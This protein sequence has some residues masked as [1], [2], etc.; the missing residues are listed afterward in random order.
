M[1]VRAAQAARRGRMDD[2]A[3]LD[4]PTVGRKS[5]GPRVF[6]VTR[7]P[8]G[9]VDHVVAVA[10]SKGLTVNAYLCTLVEDLHGFPRSEVQEAEPFEI[11][12]A[13]PIPRTAATSRLRF[14]LV[15]SLAEHI[16]DAAS[17]QNMDRAPYLTALV[18]Q[19]HG[20]DVARR[21]TPH[22]FASA[23]TPEPLPELAAT[24][25]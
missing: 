22:P 17:R 20:F 7:A 16:T 18:A 14:R 1:S 6:I 15:R 23:Y 12:R 21:V 5:K 11:V 24:G 9:L 2:P 4:V 19:A 3:V 13:N 8:Q 25:S 10:D